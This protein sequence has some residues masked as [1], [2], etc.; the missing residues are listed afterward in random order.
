M[1]E[2]WI[3][4]HSVYTNARLIV[5]QINH[6]SPGKMLLNS[7]YLLSVRCVFCYFISSICLQK[8]FMTSGN[9]MQFIHVLFQIY[10]SCFFL[11]DLQLTLEHISRAVSMRSCMDN[12]LS[13]IQLAYFKKKNVNLGVASYHSWGHHDWLTAVYIP[14]S[15]LSSC[16][17]P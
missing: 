10:W 16:A 14:V 4:M 11:Y 2:S 9:F 3:K 7:C 13:L 15:N 1:R 17:F 6:Y 5:S 12:N 8:Y